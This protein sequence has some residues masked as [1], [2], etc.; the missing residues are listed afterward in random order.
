MFKIYLANC[1]ALINNA[2]FIIINTPKKVLFKPTNKSNLIIWLFFH[3]NMARGSR[4]V[5]CIFLIMNT[6][7]LMLKR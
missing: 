5:E 7:T 1:N 4:V 6:P 2:F 3:D